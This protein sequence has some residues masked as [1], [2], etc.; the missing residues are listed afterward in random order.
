MRKERHRI[1]P[2]TLAPGWLALG[3]SCDYMSSLMGQPLNAKAGSDFH[4]QLSHGVALRKC[5]PPF[6]R[7]ETKCWEM[8][9]HLRVQ[10]KG[11][12]ETEQRIPRGMGFSIDQISPGSQY[13]CLFTVS[14]LRKI[15]NFLIYTSNELEVGIKILK[16]MSI[17]QTI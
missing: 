12:K 16:K 2:L 4:S 17:E 6:I 10:K 13:F 8:W 11:W 9:Q 3:R 5:L 14:L 1:L 7:R 15:S